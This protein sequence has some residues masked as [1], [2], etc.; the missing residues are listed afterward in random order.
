M[1]RTTKQLEALHAESRTRIIQSAMALFARHGYTNTSVR[2]IAE[3]AGIAQ[4]LM[5]RYFA[6]KAA[7]LLTILLTFLDE[8]QH[9]LTTAAAV[10][11]PHA[12]LE[13]I[14]RVSFATIQQNPQRWSLFYAIR[15][16]PEVLEAFGE[17][18]QTFTRQMLALLAEP[19]AQLGAADP[20]TEAIILFGSI[21]GV[22]QQYVYQPD[23]FPLDDVVACLVEK[24]R[25]F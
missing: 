4:G 5:Y 18:N 9:L 16:Q 13:Q 22:A 19:F 20:Q 3:H 14:I 21:D 2:R 1:P 24:Y 10:R 17:R 11:D 15:T 25:T 23:L 12:R 6:S 8:V 7:L